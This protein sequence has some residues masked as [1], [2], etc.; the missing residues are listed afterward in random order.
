MLE[1]TH[2]A[3][4]R[5]TCATL[6]GC[7]GRAPKLRRLPSAIALWRGS[8]IEDVAYAIEIPWLKGEDESAGRVTPSLLRG[9]GFVASLGL[10]PA[11]DNVVDVVASA[12]LRLSAAAFLTLASGPGGRFVVALAK[13]AQNV[14]LLAVCRLTSS[15]R[16]TNSWRNVFYMPK[17]AVGR[18]R[19]K[20]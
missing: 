12:A 19:Q 13:D 15:A 20:P 5:E 6:K 11:V 8:L 10:A 14:A 17:T 9:E 18:G 1:L 2:R 16:S 7:C 3:W 4:K